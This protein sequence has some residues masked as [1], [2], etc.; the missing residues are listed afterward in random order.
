[1][2]GVT[3]WS[4]CV[5]GESPNYTPETIDTA[6]IAITKWVAP[7]VL[8]TAFAAAGRRP[9]RAG[10]GLPRPQHGEGRRRDGHLGARRRR[11]RDCRSA[12]CIGGTRTSIA[13][14]ISLGIEKSPAAL[15]AKARAAVA[16]GL[17][18][19]QDQDHAGI[20][21]R[22]RARGARGARAVGAAHGRREQRLHARR[23]RSARGARHAR[24]DDD[25]AAARLGRH[26]S[27]RASCSSAS[28]RRSVSTSRSR[29]ST[30]R[31][32]CTR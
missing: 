22:V 18:Q 4:E 11:R 14:G 30:A 26:R 15:V 32:T 23:H 5:A 21:R 20:R 29:R 28:R 17:S 31:S 2:N 1:M 6:W 10:Q 12:G 19:G 7:R 16:G 8:G 9:R 27:P 25:R 24:P 3:A 13:T